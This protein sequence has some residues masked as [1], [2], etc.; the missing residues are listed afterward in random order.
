MVILIHIKCIVH[1]V[2]KSV[3]PAMDQQNYVKFVQELELGNLYVDVQK[4]ILKILIKNVNNVIQLVKIV[5]NM[6]VYLVLVI[7]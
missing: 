6:V 1:N 5:I 7:E 4:V 2:Q 3:S